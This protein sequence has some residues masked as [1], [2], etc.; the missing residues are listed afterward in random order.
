MKLGEEKRDCKHFRGDI[1]CKPHKKEGVVCPTCQYYDPLN[2]RI[3]II[4]LGA[5]GDVIRT[6]PLLRKLRELYPKSEITWLTHTPEFV[7]KTWVDRILRFEIH[8]LITL[9]AEHFDLL[10]NLDKDR[11]ACALANLISATT[12]KGYYLLNGKPAPI[13]ADS[14]HKYLTGIDDNLNKAN[15]KHYVQEI[16]ELCGFTWNKEEYILEI[17]PSTLHLPS[18]GKPVIGLATGV[19]A[20]WKTRLW[21]VGHWINLARTL[22]ESG[23]A[24]ILLGGIDEHEQNRVIAEHS[25]ATYLGHYPLNDFIHIVNYCDLVVTAVTMTTHIAIALKKKIILF[26][27]I[28]PTTEFE[29][30]GLG[31]IVE[32]H[33]PCQGCFRNTCDIR[34]EGKTCMELITVET[35]MQEIKTLRPI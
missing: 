18:F 10:I 20:R 11:E 17:P 8:H 25:G 33:V 31:S 6:T 28:F 2:K 16:F 34:F 23:Y 7:P 15:T 13:D 29:L 27:N 26:V 3:L 24:V 35:V 32:P 22:Q 5:R 21:S 4:K 9:Q 1:P 19:G 14:A 12:K 30:Y